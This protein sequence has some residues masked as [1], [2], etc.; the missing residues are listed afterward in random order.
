MPAY[1]DALKRDL[2][3]LGIELVAPLARLGSDGDYCGLGEEHAA[4]GLLRDVENAYYLGCGT[5]IAEALKLRGRLVPFDQAAP[6]ILK[7]WQMPTALGPTFENL[8]SVDAMNRVYARLRPHE[9]VATTHRNDIPYPEVGAASGEPLAQAWMSVAALV[10]AELIFERLWTI[11]NGRADC[12]HRGVEYGAL[13]PNHEYRGVLLD[14]V[15]VG[16]RGG[17]IYAKPATRGVFA[18]NVERHLAALVRICGDE[19]LSTRYLAGGSDELASGFVQPSRLRAA[20]ALGAAVAA[21]RAF[22]GHRT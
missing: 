15:V 7:A 22:A 10:L 19:Q 5:G 11:K 3:E 17:A 12:P 14:R 9:A 1:L 2:T 20:P 18:E 6:W 4:D 21:A 13:Q 16:Q 8:V